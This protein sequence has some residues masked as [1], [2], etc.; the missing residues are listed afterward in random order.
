MRVES[1]SAG[2]LLICVSAAVL[3]VAKGFVRLP[4]LRTLSLGRLALVMR[5]V[6][7]LRVLGPLEGEGVARTG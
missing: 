4:G 7:P 1:V 6:R 3:L 5:N 2:S